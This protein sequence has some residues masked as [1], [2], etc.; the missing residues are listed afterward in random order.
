MELSNPPLKLLIYENK[1]LP[2]R[3]NWSFDWNRPGLSGVSKR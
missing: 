2:Y 1:N 3:I